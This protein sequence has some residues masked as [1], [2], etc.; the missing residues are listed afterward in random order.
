IAEL[1]T[2]T[3]KHSGATHAWVHINHGRQ[4]LVITITDNG[5]GGATPTPA[6]GLGGIARRLDAFDGTMNITSPTGGPTIITLEIP[7]AL[8]SPKTL[9]SSATDS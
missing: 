5:H 4:R 1:L 9:P 2:N 8:S 6:S 7:C 3:A